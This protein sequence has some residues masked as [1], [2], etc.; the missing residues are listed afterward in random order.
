MRY[1]NLAL[2]LCGLL[3]L[4]GC[5]SF[6]PKPL[7]QVP[8]LERAKTEEKDGVRV[9]VSV[10][11]RKETKQVFGFDL[12]KKGIQTIWIDIEN[13]TDRPY[14]FMLSGV[15]PNY[16]SAREA[17]YICHSFWRR[18]KNRKMD[19]H[20]EN[21]FIDQL[22]LP[23]CRS[24]GFG[25]SY[26]KQGVRE[27]RVRLFGDLNIIDYE[28]HIPVPGLRTDWEVVDF[29]A[30]YPEEAII[31][32]EDEPSLREALEPLPLTTTKENGS[33]EGD[34]LNI[35]VIGHVEKP[36]TRARWDE[37]E[38]LTAGTA[39]KTAKGFFGKEYKHSPMS[40]LYV[41]GRHQDIGL[42]KARDSIHERNHLRLWL[43]PI[44]YQGRPVC[45]GTIT[46]DIGVYFT[47]RAWNLMTHAIDPDVD[48]ARDYLT[49]DLAMALSLKKY[50]Y[51]DGV[52]PATQDSPHRNLM[53][54]PYWTD[55]SRVILLVT[56][57][58]VPLGDIDHFDWER[59]LDQN[60]CKDPVSE[61]GSVESGEE[62]EPGSSEVPPLL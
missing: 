10:L 4:S 46:R 47:T 6:K 38:R 25:F 40:S 56:D 55:G 20:F 27:V 28:F 19:Q 52:A 58:V 61:E 21:L 57:D 17:A 51:L 9:T 59:R 18:S 36:F 34:P 62:K 26:L 7:E 30:L 45:V 23:R 37:T 44:R 50:G 2:V 3:L 5:A 53:K 49:E 1:S 29:D 14:W 42:Q 11:T 8:F 13:S 31:H 16:Y 24:A 48:E 33:G 54:A 12:E 32:V 22:V 60:Q 43:T 35:V 15:D 41:F 39:W